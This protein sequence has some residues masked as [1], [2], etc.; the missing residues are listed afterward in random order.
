[1]SSAVTS[2]SP[3][4]SS[5]LASPAVASSASAAR[6]KRYRP[7]ST[8]AKFGNSGCARSTSGLWSSALALVAGDDILPFRWDRCAMAVGTRSY[9]KRAG[10]LCLVGP[11]PPPTTARIQSSGAEQSRPGQ[12]MAAPAAPAARPGLLLLRRT[13]AT[14]SAALRAR[15][16]V[17]DFY[18]SGAPL[19]AF[20]VAAAAE[21]D[22]PRAALVVAGGA[23]LVDAAFMDAVPSLRCVV[24][25][26]AGVDHIDLAAC[27]RRGVAVA[28][29]GKIFSVDVADHAVGL[30]IA[31]CICCIHTT[32]VY[33]LVVASCGTFVSVV[34]NGVVECFKMMNKSSTADCRGTAPY[35]VC[36]CCQEI[37]SSQYKIK[38]KNQMFVSEQNPIGQ[39]PASQDKLLCHTNSSPPATATDA[40]SLTS[41][42]H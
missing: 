33:E 31:V 34:I 8:A 9:G 3:G 39:L 5:T 24:T 19:G 32:Y 2:L 35:S 12:A 13:D 40:A 28:G 10:L 18:A 15:Y 20:L 38:E 29:A 17:L 25:T 37:V 4:T 26:G 14:F 42:I 1:M 11:D 23:V 30:L 7:S 16:R 22:P 41:I 6:A 27:A 21:P 36:I